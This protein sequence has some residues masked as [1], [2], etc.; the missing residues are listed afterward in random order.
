MGQPPLWRQLIKSIYPESPDFLTL[1]CMLMPTV[2]IQNWHSGR[3]IEREVFDNGDFQ[4]D[5]ETLASQNLEC[6]NRFWRIVAPEE[7]L[8]V[9]LLKPDKQALYTFFFVKSYPNRY[10]YQ[11]VEELLGAVLRFSQE[12]VPA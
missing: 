12:T 11:S 4:F 3:V 7:R 2:K 10:Q 5:T 6:I 1:L 9:G 8:E